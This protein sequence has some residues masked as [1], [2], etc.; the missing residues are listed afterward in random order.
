MNTANV[1]RVVVPGG[2][3][4][5]RR[6]SLTD[7]V[8]LPDSRSSRSTSTSGSHGSTRSHLT[9]GSPCSVASPARFAGSWAATGGRTTCCLAA[10]N[11]RTRRH[12][13]LQPALMR[14]AGT[15]KI[16]PRLGLLALGHL[17]PTK[18]STTGQ[19]SGGEVRTPGNLHRRSASAGTGA[20]PPRDRRRQRIA[21]A[22][23][24]PRDRPGASV[25]AAFS[26]VRE[27]ALGASRAGLARGR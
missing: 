27:G 19:S 26:G 2:V 12:A 4:R 11:V 13:G 25:E 24:T 16:K 17:L 5:G 15:S 22:G 21:P 7:S 20:L 10:L 6:R 3:E 18:P 1:E 8:P 23:P 9:S 14:L